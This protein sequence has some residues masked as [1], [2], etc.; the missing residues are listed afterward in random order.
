MPTSLRCGTRT[1][2]LYT[3]GALF[4]NRSVSRSRRP[5]AARLA[6]VLL[7]AWLGSLLLFGGVVAPAAFSVAPT[8]AV[9]GNLVGRVLAPLDWA[10]VATGLVLA[11]VAVG[12][13][14]GVWRIALPALMSLGSLVSRLLLAPEIESLRPLLD[15]ASARARFGLLH[16][17]S[18]GIFAGVGFAGFAL[19]VL[20]LRAVEPKKSG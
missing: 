18:V 11:G 5:L 12:L 19:V 1:A 13:G 2:R 20:H 9:A 14:Q 7:G 16:G 4:Q 6:L 3:P 8:P 17:L 15:Q 10:G